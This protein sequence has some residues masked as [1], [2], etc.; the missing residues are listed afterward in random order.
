VFAGILEIAAVGYVLVKG[1]A[2]LR[3]RLLVWHQEATA[4]STV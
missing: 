4:P 3:S 1:M 2:L